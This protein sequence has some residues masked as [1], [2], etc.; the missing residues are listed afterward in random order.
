[1]TEHTRGVL[2]RFFDGRFDRSILSDLGA[3]AG[4]ALV[5]V[6]LA[7][8]NVA[9]AYI[10]AGLILAGASAIAALPPKKRGPSTPKGDA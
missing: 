9:A 3:F 8:L 7:R 10:V 5:I 1:M 2:V 4:A 6:G